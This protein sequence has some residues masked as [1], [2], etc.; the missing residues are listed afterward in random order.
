MMSEK[1]Y[2][3][4]FNKDPKIGPPKELPQGSKVVFSSDKK[5][6]KDPPIFWYTRVWWHYD[7]NGRYLPTREGADGPRGFG[8]RHY[9][10]AHNITTERAIKTA[11]EHNYPAEGPSHGNHLE[12]LAFIT[13]TQGDIELTVR[14]INEQ[15]ASTSDGVYTTPNGEPIGTITAFCEGVNVC[16]NYVN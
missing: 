8:Y 1:E 15:G 3:E 13:D 16:P 6:I 5:E 11:Y 9:A 14:V 7:L 4:T 2:R 10:A 12:Y